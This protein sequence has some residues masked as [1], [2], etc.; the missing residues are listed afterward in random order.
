VHR[1]S[2][3]SPNSGISWRNSKC[4]FENRNKD[5]QWNLSYTDPTGPALFH[6]SEMFVYVK[7]R[8]KESLKEQCIS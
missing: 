1:M 5:I 7:H 6:I 2:Q 8:I 4:T 3:I